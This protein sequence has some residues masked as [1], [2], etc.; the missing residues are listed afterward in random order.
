MQKLI[1]CL[2]FDGR[3]E[4]AANYYVSVFKNSKIG[5]IAYYGDSGP[6]EKGTV[7][8]IIF[9]LNGQEFMAINGGPHFTFTPAISFI[10]NCENQEEVDFM[11][12]KL[13]E[14]GAEENCGWVKDKFGVSWQIVPT[15][16]EKLMSS[17]DS[18]K[19]NRVMQALLKMNKLDIAKLEAAY[20]EKS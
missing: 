6:M 19:S 4:E 13:S 5:K 17:S 12:D 8:T 20:D 1:P 7:M 16:L 2:W 11:W 18:E 3:A 14:G 15:V 10:V 9:Q